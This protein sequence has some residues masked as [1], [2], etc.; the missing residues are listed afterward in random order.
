MI[1]FLYQ[2]A[3]LFKSTVF[4]EKI[5]KLFESIPDALGSSKKDFKISKIISKT[6]LD[7][8]QLEYS[9]AEYLSDLPK[10]FREIALRWIKTLDDKSGPSFYNSLITKIQDAKSFNLVL[11]SLRS[12]QCMNNQNYSPYSNDSSDYTS[13][14]DS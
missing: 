10:G 2:H 3:S 6:F 12:S 5:E 13:S 9:D 7:L 8:S 11:T 14:D 4:A 1:K